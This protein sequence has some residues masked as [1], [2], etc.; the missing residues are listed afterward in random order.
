MLK[1]GPSRLLKKLLTRDMLIALSLVS[2]CPD[3]RHIRGALLTRSATYLPRVWAGKQ[4]AQ[5][6][7]FSVM[8]LLLNRALLEP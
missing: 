1:P 3:S 5:I 2:V 4:V 6:P 8:I 7:T